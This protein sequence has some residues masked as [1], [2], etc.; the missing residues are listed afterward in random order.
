M[1]LELSRFMT[2]SQNR[3]FITAQSVIYFTGSEYPSLF[4]MH[5]R[6]LM[7]KDFLVEVIDMAQEETV[8]VMNRLSTS[9][10]GNRVVYFITGI[11]T[12]SRAKGFNFFT[13]LESYSG[14]HIIVLHAPQEKL[15]QDKHVLIITIPDKVDK[16]LFSVLISWFNVSASTQVKDFT[17]RLFD[18]I[19]QL[20]FEQACILMRYA[21]LG[22]NE[23]LF[24]EKWLSFIITPEQSMFS[25]SQY[26]FQKDAHQFF[27]QWK[28]VMDA[29]SVQF[30][31]VFWSEQL[32]R[33]SMFIHLS[34]QRNYADARKIAFRLPF[35]FINRDW[36][37]YTG[38]ELIA[39]HDF[40]YQ[41]D[42][43]SKNSDNLVGLDLF[44]SRF[45]SSQF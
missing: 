43:R 13:Y 4:F 27:I 34:K 44:Y 14:P 12:D 6:L 39:A 16:L 24:F 45:L 36:R 35:S 2:E 41:L 28:Q 20:S 22:V 11:D 30:W 32:W 18:R 8:V 26:L 29:Y 10:L 17:Q 3:D 5:M 23:K 1:R 37:S 15:S 42:Y 33:A 25:L 40:L 7:Q 31:I 38:N 21:P 19:D 9:F